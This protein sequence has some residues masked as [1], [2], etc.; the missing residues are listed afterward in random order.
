MDTKL[1]NGFKEWLEDVVPTLTDPP[2]TG[3]QVFEILSDGTASSQITVE[4]AV[5]VLEVQASRR[6]PH[7]ALDNKYYIRSGSKNRP[8]GHQEVIGLMQW[9]E[10]PQL[11]LSSVGI[12]PYLHVNAVMAVKLTNVGNRRISAFQCDLFLPTVIDALGSLNC[13]EG[14]MI[15]LDGIMW[16]RL[17]I[18]RTTPLFPQQ[19]VVTRF[20]LKTFGSWDPEF[21]NSSSHAE[22]TLWAD[23][24]FPIKGVLPITQILKERLSFQDTENL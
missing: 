5:Y 10:A 15:K 2:L 20:H 13:K 9:R 11:E 12:Q 23:D 4:R 1:K 8:V 18:R 21:R 7:Q 3:F 19:S 14:E 22:Y 24:L 17:P 6:P 16:L